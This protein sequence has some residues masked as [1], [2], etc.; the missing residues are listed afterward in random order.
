MNA[1]KIALFPDTNLFLHYRPLNEIDWC[2]LLQS[3]TVEIEIAPVVARE[4]ETQKTLNQSEKLR[5][6]AETALKLL[7]KHLADPQVREG[8]GAHTGGGRSSVLCYTRT[9]SPDR[10]QGS[11]QAAPSVAV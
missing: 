1:R 5:D 2:S 10:S 11:A 3:S 9:D 4:L 7:H 6:R 8:V